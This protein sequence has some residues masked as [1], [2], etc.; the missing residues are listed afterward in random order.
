MSAPID[1]LLAALGGVDLADIGRLP[2]T[3]VEEAIDSLRL[4]LAERARL[5]L[6]LPS[7]AKEGDLGAYFLRQEERT[8]DPWRVY[9]ERELAL[10]R[11]AALATDKELE[12][13]FVDAARAQLISPSDAFSANYVL[14]GNADAQK[15]FLTISLLPY[16]DRLRMHNFFI[17][18]SCG[19]DFLTTFGEQL[20][21]LPFPLFPPLPSLRALNIKLLTEGR[22]NGGGSR[23]GYPSVF[24]QETEGGTVL[25]VLMDEAGRAFVD[26][27][28]LVWM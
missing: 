5:H 15:F 4:P 26:L 20:I 3:L 2:P 12:R 17:A 11:S 18:S 21:S 27:P 22:T 25:P 8:R 19:T 7:P 13:S 9:L 16:A 28:L 23:E 14:F 1:Q 10:S 6:T 24:R